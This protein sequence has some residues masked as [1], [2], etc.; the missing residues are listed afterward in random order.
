MSTEP[1]PADPVFVRYR[2][3][4]G[5]TAWRK[6]LPYFIRW[7]LSPWHDGRQWLLEA[8]DFDRDADRTF[9]L[10]DVLAWQTEPPAPETPS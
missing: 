8:Y 7:G 10:K 2:N 6:I 1:T 5:E 9:A 4:R 3:H